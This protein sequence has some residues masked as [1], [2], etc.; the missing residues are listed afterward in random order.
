M[1][2]ERPRPWGC[3]MTSL[4]IA[5]VG[6]MVW[7]FL[8]G[9]VGDI[10]EKRG[11]SGLLWF[12]VSFFCSPLIGYFVVELLPSAADHA[13]VEYTWCRYCLRTVRVG[14]DI[15]PYCHADLARKPAA[16]KKAA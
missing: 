5:I 15:C 2:A 9:M 12:F 1:R 4:L 10:A 11:H 14:T 3:A 7:T 8:C 13:A 6:V 16:Q